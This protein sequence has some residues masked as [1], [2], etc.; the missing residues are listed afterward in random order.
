LPEL[1][2][3][4]GQM[5]GVDCGLRRA[6]LVLVGDQAEGGQAWL[7]AHRP[8]CHWGQLANFEPALTRGESD[9]LLLAGLRRVR[10]SRLAH[11]LRLA[12]P[13]WQ[14]PVISGRPVARLNVAGNIVLGV[15][16]ADGRS[17]GAESVVLAAGSR[18]NPLLFDSGLETVSIDPPKVAQLLF[19]P[20]ERLVQHA[21]NTGDC[22]LVPLHDGRIL[23]IDLVGTIQEPE[24]A[25]ADLLERVGNWLP[26]LSRFDL[27]ASGLGPGPVLDEQR[28]AIGAYPQMRALWLNA[29]HARRGLDI[30]LAAAETL[31][32]QLDG[33][34]VEKALAVRLDTVA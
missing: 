1:V 32:A 13:R 31:A 5:T 23:A 34:P 7:E 28:P 22:A 11:A 8:D 16:L 25:V 2:T 27:E 14:V 18:I 21:I 30:S 17:L 4:L 9:A 20:G 33:G 12:L 3:R 26:A 15:E 6:G 10:A 29:G 24:P 19:N